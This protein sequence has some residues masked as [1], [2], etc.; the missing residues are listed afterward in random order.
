LVNARC[1]HSSMS[2]ERLLPRR[3]PVSL[4]PESGEYSRGVIK[5]RAL[6]EEG[7]EKLEEFI[8]QIMTERGIPGLSIAAMDEEGI[9][10]KRG[11][12]FRDFNLNTSTTPRTIYCIGSVTKPFTALAVMQ[13]HEEGLLNLDDPIEKYVPYKAR[14]MGE[15]ILIKHLLSHSSG[16][17]SLG[18]ASVTL[19]T[20]TN[21]SDDWFPISSPQD[22]LVFM[23]GA[24]DWALSKPGQRYAYLNAGYI[25]LGLII[26]KASGEYYADYV[27][28]H[29]L[30]PLRM[31]RSTFYKEDVEKDD[32]VATPYIVSREEGRTPTRYPYGHLI[33]DGGLMSSVEDMANFVK[34]LLSDGLFEGHQVFKPESIKMMMEPKVPILSEP[35]EGGSQIHYGYGLR[36]KTEFLG[37]TLIHHSGSVYGSSAYMG[38][39]PERD[40]GVVLIAN[41]GY[42][43]GDMGEYTLALLLGRDPM[44]MPYFR[45]QKILEELTGSYTTFR[46]TSNYKVTR[47]GGILQLQTSFGRSSYATPLIPVDL[48]GEPKLFKTYGIDSVTP[49]EFVTSED[50]IFLIYDRNKAKKTVDG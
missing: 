50:G 23:A 20:V 2:A 41:G 42:F 10:F 47:R 25:L 35:I 15:P 1:F 7:R 39:I 33:S 24:E 26:E 34:M 32:D 31:D 13:L 43:L 6:G 28:G 38:L 17:P 49:V 8:F 22:L 4:V 48:Y 3:F 5:M 21:L 11:L 45:R 29:I 16:L 30:E 14:P 46:G 19:S 18:Y 37:H 40:L 12:G 36:I 27:K 44:E 9:C